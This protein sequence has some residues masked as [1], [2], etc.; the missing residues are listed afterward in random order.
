[1]LDFASP[2]IP[3]EPL[4]MSWLTTVYGFIAKVMLWPLDVVD[5]LYVRT[6]SDQNCLFTK[7][8]RTFMLVF[9]V[10]WYSFIAYGCLYL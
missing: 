7:R 4:Q 8:D 6:C 10:V 9:M 2:F 3:W 1:M 5:W